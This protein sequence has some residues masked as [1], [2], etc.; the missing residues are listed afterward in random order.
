MLGHSVTE[1]LQ[2]LQAGQWEAAKEIWERYV[3]RL[4]NLAFA[5]NGKERPSHERFRVALV[6][7]APRG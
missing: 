3:T 1:L 6:A 5:R 7:I 4:I 2:Q